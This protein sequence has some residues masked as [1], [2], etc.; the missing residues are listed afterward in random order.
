MNDLNQFD[1]INSN[2]YNSMESDCGENKISFRDICLWS[3]KHFEDTFVI[4]WF[5]ICA[6]FLVGRL[7]NQLPISN[8]IS[9]TTDR[10]K[11]TVIKCGR[12]SLATANKTDKAPKSKVQSGVTES[13][14]HAYAWYHVLIQHFNVYI[15]KVLYLNSWFI[16]PPILLLRG[17][18]T[19]AKQPPPIL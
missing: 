13:E 8:H 17:N 15:I 11:R 4:C 14:V 12:W 3:C 9:L 5:N 19:R 10:S 7:K 18:K 6:K 1:Q 16:T 2:I